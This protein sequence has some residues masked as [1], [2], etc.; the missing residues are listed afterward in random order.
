MESNVKSKIYTIDELRKK[1]FPVFSQSPVY[2][3]VLF[4]SYAK[5]NATNISDVDIVIDSKGEL[6]NINFFGVIAAAEDAIGKDIDMLEISQIRPD[7]PILNHITSE[8]VILY[9]RQ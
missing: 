2:K 4:G 8:G 9:E 5:G 6:I 3:A 7:S 1:L